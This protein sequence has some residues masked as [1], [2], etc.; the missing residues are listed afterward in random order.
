[1]YMC[2]LPIP[3][4]DVRPEGDGLMHWYMLDTDDSALAATTGVPADQPAC[5]ILFN[6]QSLPTD[7]LC[8]TGISWS[9]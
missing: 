8:T 4:S 6:D 5:C 1:M 7:Q 2:V 3:I 9:P